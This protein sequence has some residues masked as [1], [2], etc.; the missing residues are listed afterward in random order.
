M[1]NKIN[2]SD[3][4]NPSFGAISKNVRL[5]I[6]NPEVK[7]LLAET[8]VKAQDIYYLKQHPTIK[9]QLNPLCN[10]QI[11]IA[12]EYSIYGKALVPYTDKKNPVKSTV[13]AIKKAIE[14]ARKLDA[15]NQEPQKLEIPEKIKIKKLKMAIRLAE[16]DK[17]K[18]E[19]EYLNWVK[20]ASYSDRLD[21][22]KLENKIEQA[23]SKIAQLKENVRT[24]EYK[25]STVKKELAKRALLGNVPLEAF[26]ASSLFN[27]NLND[28]YRKA[29]F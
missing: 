25:Y 7:N 4:K 15:I 22:F 16:N 18:L 27:P 11:D 13:E 8:G 5:L 9:L 24:I 28:T 1:N 12:S 21:N 20:K 29:G 23:Y 2:T 19:Q 14:T 17:I 10:D 3:L 6:K 26:N